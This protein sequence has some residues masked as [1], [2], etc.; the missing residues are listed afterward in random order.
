MTNASLILLGLVGLFIVMLIAGFVRRF[1]LPARTL[2]RDLFSARERLASLQSNAG[3]A[4]T[5]LNAIA[6]GVFSA[7]RFAHAWREY[8]ETLHAQYHV[9][10]L[11][12]RR[13]RR[14]RATTLAS[15]FFS[16]SALVETPLQTEYFKHLPGIL[17]GLGI[18]GTF[19]GLIFGLMEFDVSNVAEIHDQLAKLMQAVWHA[20]FVSALAI[21]AA[22]VI[23]WWE[24]RTLAELLGFV[25]DIAGSIDALFAAGAA[26]EYL[27]RLVE[28]SETQATQAAQIKD[29]LVADLREI[30]TTLVDKQIG[31][32]Q[33]HSAQVAADLGKA[34]SDSLGAPM[35]AIGEAV[36]K[37]TADQGDAVS[38]MLTDVLSSFSAQMREMFGG[39]MEGMT[40]LLQET[41]RQMQATAG[42]FASLADSMKDAGNSA[43]D[44]MA[45]RLS[46]AITSMEA[47]QSVLNKHM[48]EYIAQIRSTVADSQTENA[49]AMQ[50]S[51][52]TM[53]RSVATM[54]TEMQQRSDAADETQREQQ[55]TF[56]DTTTSLVGAMSKSMEDLLAQSEKTQRELQASVTELS[57]TTRSAISEMNSGAETLYL[58]ATEFAKAG[59]GVGAVID[60]V[61]S[62]V[63]LLD[64]AAS[65]L[66]L[67]ATSTSSATAEYA[68]SRDA[69]GELVSELRTI[70]EASMQDRVRVADVVKEFEKAAST[71]KQA[72]S[73]A[74]EHLVQLTKVL[75]EAHEAFA[76]AI[77]TT[78]RKANAQ[79]GKELQTSVGI[80][81]AAVKDLGDALEDLPAR[82]S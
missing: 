52:D 10:E 47:R 9:D 38:R 82:R 26:D 16:E 46:A 55:R 53:G 71:L 34:I 45:E 48:G 57:E 37:V 20:F 21:A 79:F 49:R 25:E 54:L 40:S 59:S 66:S 18:I 7:T 75:G 22:M 77:E 68:R 64:S 1:V 70:I 61:E 28:A 2:R 60:K 33:Q 19:T 41:S 6:S 63:D 76:A 72:Q 4:T 74:D 30:L 11:G 31:A 15:T 69:L 78:L 17:T 23:T 13:V 80:V 5:D 56:S 14:W 62:S 65:S 24:K 12:Q 81:S 51:V 58:A 67:A 8:S 73:A 39:Q 42:Q 27:S 35:L 43:A 44:A 29:A 3:A 36:K 50:A 32:Q